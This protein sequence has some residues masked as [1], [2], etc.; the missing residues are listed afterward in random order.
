MITHSPTTSY[1]LEEARPLEIES[2]NGNNSWFGSIVLVGGTIRSG[3][4]GWA[5]VSVKSER[6]EVRCKPIHFHPTPAMPRSSTNPTPTAP[7]A[8]V[9]GWKCLES[10]PDRFDAFM[11]LSEW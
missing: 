7:A 11:A 9:G 6:S 8:D 3:A 1:F 10:D 5:S 4:D 2:A